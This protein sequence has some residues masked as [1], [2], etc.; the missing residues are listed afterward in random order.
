[1]KEELK[2]IIIG[3]LGTF[4][5]TQALKVPSSLEEELKNKNN[6]F[7][8]TTKRQIINDSCMWCYQF[9]EEEDTSTPYFI[10]IEIQ[11]EF[12]TVVAINVITD[13][14]NKITKYS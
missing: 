8:I 14:K 12:K 13:E 5:E 6:W 11:T 2:D 9:R 7:L 3:T 1:M 4:I 10:Q